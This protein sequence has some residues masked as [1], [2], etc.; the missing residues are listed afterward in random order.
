MVQPQRLSITSLPQC[1]VTSGRPEPSL[2]LRVSVPWTGVPSVQGGVR[3][4]RGAAGSAGPSEKAKNPEL[5]IKRP[6]FLFFSDV[7]K[8]TFL[9]K[10]RKQTGP[11]GGTHS[12]PGLTMRPLSIYWC[13]L[14]ARRCSKSAT[15]L[16]P[17]PPH[18]PTWGSWYLTAWRPR[19]REGEEFACSHTASREQDTLEA[20]RAALWL[21]CQLPLGGAVLREMPQ[22]VLTGGA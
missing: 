1:C 3:P 7:N 22:L 18:Q 11:P 20:G 5:G 6:D 19:P 13:L 21:C 2:C 14:Y 17:L 8:C 4:C 12:A 9:K 15:C 10:I 16:N